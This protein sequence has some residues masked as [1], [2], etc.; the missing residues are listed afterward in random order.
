MVIRITTARI[1]DLLPEEYLGLDVTR[2][3]GMRTLAPTWGLVRNY[4][5]GRIDEAAYEKVYRRL[6]ARSQAEHSI[7]WDGLLEVGAKGKI[8]CFQCYC[9]R[10]R[11]CHR[12][13]LAH[14][15]KEYAEARGHEVRMI[16]E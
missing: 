13:I 2:K 14:M 16:G 7:V 9:G 11:F 5:A 8:L 6:M 15:V 3:S 10:G 1:G 12:L 4:K